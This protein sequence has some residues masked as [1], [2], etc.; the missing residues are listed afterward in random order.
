MTAAARALHGAV[1]GW[2]LQPI[3]LPAMSYTLLQPA[4]RRSPG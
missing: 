1:V 2:D 3:Q 4:G